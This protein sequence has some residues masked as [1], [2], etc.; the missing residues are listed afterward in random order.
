MKIA[1]LAWGSLLWSPRELKIDQSEWNTDGPN[2]PIEFSRIASD[3]R[4]TLVIDL[5]FDDVQTYWHVMDTNDL[6]DARKNLQLREGA[7]LL[8][9]IGFVSGDQYQIRDDAIFLIGRI[10]SWM[11]SKNLDAVIWTDLKPKFYEKTGVKF[12]DGSALEYLKSLKGEVLSRAREY[13]LNTPEQTKTRLRE[14]LE[15]HLNKKSP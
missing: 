3:G 9:E 2:L 1:V 13:I 4:L 8:E 5:D 7:D 11:E 15:N 10:R 14:T 6:E 12:S